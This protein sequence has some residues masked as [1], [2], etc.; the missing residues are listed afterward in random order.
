MGN[1][2]HN[3]IPMEPAGHAGDIDEL[4][5]QRYLD[6]RL[7][8][9]ARADVDELLKK[10]AAARRTLNAMREEE[11][12]IRQA[13][14]SRIEP[15]RRIADKVLVALHNEERFRLNALRNRRLRR[16]VVGV[17]ATAATILLCLWLVKPRD[18]AGTAVSGTLA[19]VITPDGSARPMNRNTPVYEG[20]IIVTRQAQFVRLKLA[21][22]VRLDIDEHSRVELERGEGTN[23]RIDSGRMGVDTTA[24]SEDVQVRLAQGSVR[25]AAS[26]TCGCRAPAARAG[27]NCSTRSAPTAAA[28]S[29]WLKATVSPRS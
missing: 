27:R 2:D 19:T 8:A 10:S 21:N 29:S 11:N 15:S 5:L 22:G 24:A 6:G 28:A 3:N 12:L 9:D 17:M 1:A 7:D 16:Q 26:P 4:L 25:V 20:D 18:A 23:V 14:E 13:L